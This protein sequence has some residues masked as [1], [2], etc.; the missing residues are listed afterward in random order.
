MGS[1]GLGRWVSVVLCVFTGGCALWGA[2]GDGHGNGNADRGMKKVRSENRDGAEVWISERDGAELSEAILRDGKHL[3][4]STRKVTV[5]QF[6]EFVSQTGYVSEAEEAGWGVVLEKGRWAAT[7]GACWRSPIGG[8]SVAEFSSAAGHLS[9]RDSEAYAKWAGM[10]LP[11][12][13]EISF[14]LALPDAEINERS[15]IDRG[16]SDSGIEEDSWLL[17]WCDGPASARGE[18]ARIGS[19][20]EGEEWQE[21]FRSLDGILGGKSHQFSGVRCVIRME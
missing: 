16:Q 17:C 19:A 7:Q 3:L 20:S 4:I 8:G 9:R 15:D 1:K 18:I 10:R 5:R 6:A 13:E 14:I 11:T 12:P 2:A 21:A